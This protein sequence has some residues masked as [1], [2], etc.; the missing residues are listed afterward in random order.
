M[1]ADAALLFVLKSQPSSGEDFKTL[2]EAPP[3]KQKSLFSDEEDSEVS[4]SSIIPYRNPWD[5][6]HSYFSPLISG[7]SLF[8]CRI[9]NS[10]IYTS[11]PSH[12]ESSFFSQ[13]E[14]S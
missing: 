7:N 4:I 12:P 1:G 14:I 10:D 11:T 8:I 5:L 2:S 6:S 13:S 9:G 3:R